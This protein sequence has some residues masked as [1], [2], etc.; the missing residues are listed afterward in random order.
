MK[1]QKRTFDIIN[2]FPQFQI[3]RKIRVI[4]HND[5]LEVIKETVRELG[6]DIQL[7]MITKTLKPINELT[8]PKAKRLEQAFRE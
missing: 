4:S 2:F 7:A 8:N 5:K 6:V 1:E 3:D